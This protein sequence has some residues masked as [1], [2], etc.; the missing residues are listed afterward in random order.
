MHTRKLIATEQGV[1]LTEFIPA[2]TIQSLDTQITHKN[3]R[4]HTSKR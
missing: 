3:D 4:Q 2:A 1:T